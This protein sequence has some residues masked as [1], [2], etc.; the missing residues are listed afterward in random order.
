VALERE[1]DMAQPG[2]IE[3]FTGQPKV[4]AAPFFLASVGSVGLLAHGGSS[5]FAS[6]NAQPDRFVQHAG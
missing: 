6:Y 1:A 5:C 2:G 4:F 3:Y